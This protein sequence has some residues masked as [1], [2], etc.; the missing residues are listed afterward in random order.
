MKTK[1]NKAITLIAL[2]V[3][4]VV[5]LILAGISINMITG[6]NGILNRTQEAKKNTEDASDL[7]Y[8]RTKAYEI[9]SK[10]YALGSN[11]KEEDYV[12]KNLNT[13]EIVSNENTG[14]VT[15]KGKTYEISEIIGTSSE[16][17]AIESQ[18][19]I[20]LEKIV[21]NTATG[22]DIELFEKGKIRM[23]IQEKNNKSLRAVIP[24]GFYY[25]T[26]APSTGLV[27][28]DKFGDDNN[29]SKGGNQFV[30][31]PCKGEGSA[32]YEKTNDE[33]VQS[34]YGLASNWAK[35]S[36][37]SRNYNDFK[38]WTDY[39]GNYESVIKYGGFYVARYE[40]GVPSDAPFY[41]NEDGA[42]YFTDEKNTTEYKPV[43]KKN[44]QVWNYVYQ[45]TAKVL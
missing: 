3:T 30:W 15:Y 9:I 27:V 25:V 17:K 20:K 29:N 8:L 45:N 26:G 36:S 18:I 1:E 21:K 5:L 38:D 10:Y 33:S 7:E 40:A 24:N 35:Y 11:D 19:D 13:S 12:M 22:D 34:K 23:I 43:S 6:Q 31:V 2:V 42:K 4:I 28:S 37:H 32:T 14:T 44:N 16:Q 39:G 41:A